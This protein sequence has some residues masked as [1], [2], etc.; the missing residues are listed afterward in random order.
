MDKRA[1][2]ELASQ[3]A[4]YFTGRSEVLAAYLYGSRA[5]G[6]ASALSDMDIGVLTR[7]GLA[8]ER[9]WRL[10]D[11]I[12]ADLRRV[13]HTDQVDLIVLNLAPLRIR[14]EVIT[15][16]KVLYSA[17]D[18]ARADFESYSLRRYWD[19]EKYLEE[20]DRCFLT[21]IKEGLD[22]TQRRQYQD[23]SA[24]VRTVHRRVKEAAG[25]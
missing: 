16:G 24:K 25:S 11:A 1:I 15:R 13:L 8:E 19:F 7:D 9:L 4:D 23:T 17:D 2:G 22:E 6:R 21:R 18:G 3:L 20:Y 10:E 5:E 14:Y 12:A